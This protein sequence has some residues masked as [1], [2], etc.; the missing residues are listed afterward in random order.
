MIHDLKTLSNSSNLSISSSAQTVQSG[1]QKAALSPQAIKG[2]RDSFEKAKQHTANLNMSGISQQ[3]AVDNPS[4]YL[5][6]LTNSEKPM[7]S[8]ATNKELSRYM[9]DVN[10]DVMTHA[11]ELNR[12]LTEAA[13]DPDLKRKDMNEKEKQRE[14]EIKKLQEE[15]E[16]A[17]DKSAWAFFG[18]IFGGDVIG[19]FEIQQAMSKYTQASAM[20][21]AIHKKD[22]ESKNEIIK[23]LG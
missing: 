3:G 23:K 7:S 12:R 6:D 16:E 10:Q 2:A 20:A 11:G 21:S 13:K 9:N 15:L 14:E 18:S 22:D 19:S 4:A 17:K 5:R 8:F 1:I